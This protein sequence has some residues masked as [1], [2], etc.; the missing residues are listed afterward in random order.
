MPD[1]RFLHRRAGHGE[2][3]NLLNDLEYRVWTQYILSSDD[4]GVMRCS[5]VTI[6]ADNDNLGARPAKLIQR[7]LD[8]LT[9]D[10]GLLRTF[11]HQNRLYAYQHDWQAWQKVVYPR[12]TNNPK[13]PPEAIES[14]DEATQKLFAIHPGGAGRKRPKGSE[15][16]PETVL[17]GSSL[18]RA[19]A[20]AKRLTANGERLEANGS[21][22]SSR[23]TAAPFDV[24]LREL[25]DAYPKHR[26][27]RGLRTEQLFMGAIFG[28]AGAPDAIFAMMRANLELNIVSDE[29]KRGYVPKLEKYLESGEWMNVLPAEGPKLAATG[30]EGRGRTGVTPGKFDGLEE[31]D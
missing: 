30:T 15:N 19:A 5:A 9:K 6:Q 26:V 20:P 1:D 11:T 18:M 16:V 7:C 25:Q 29:W 8:V 14:C 23:E 4:F 3:S 27:T 24:W 28:Q 22:G 10:G 12:T 2:K 17:D 31:T 13:P 21:E